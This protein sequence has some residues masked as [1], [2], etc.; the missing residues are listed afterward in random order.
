MRK[1]IL[2]VLTLLTAALCMGQSD[3]I[4]NQGGGATQELSYDSATGQMSITDAQGA[5]ITL[6]TGAS[7]SSDGQRGLV[8][9][10]L[11]GEEGL[12]LRGDGTWA[13]PTVGGDNWGS[14][15][16]QSS[17]FVGGNGTAANRLRLVQNGATDGQVIAWDNGLGEWD[18]R[19]QL[20]SQL[21]SLSA[22]TLELTNGG[23]V[24]LSGYLDN[25]DTQDLSLAANVLSL[26]DGGSVDLSGYLD[27]TDTQ[28]L[29]LAGTTL[30]L[31]NGGSVDLSALQDGT[32]TDDQELTLTGNTL[33]IEGGNSVSLAAYLDNTDTQDLSLAGSV[34]SLTNGGSVDLSSLGGG[35]PD[36]TL[37]FS[38]TT[39][40]I[41]GGNSVNLSSLLDNTDTQDL[42]LSGSVLSLTN[43]GSVDLSN[44]DDSDIQFI[45]INTSG[46]FLQFS[47]TDAN[48][49][50]LNLFTDVT[51]GGG[52]SQLNPLY[53][54]TTYI[55]TQYDLTNATA[56]A[57]NG[58]SIDS[59]SGDVVLGG[60]MTQKAVIEME[61]QAI[62]FNADNNG[63]TD[64]DAVSDS[65]FI[66]FIDGRGVV[67][68]FG[69]SD[70]NQPGYLLMDRVYGSDYTK[71]IAYNESD[72]INVG[73][74]S[75]ELELVG[76]EYYLNSGF[77]VDTLAA[78]TVDYLLGFNSSTGQFGPTTQ[79]TT[80]G[81]GSSGGG[82]FSTTNNVT[83]NAPG[84]YANDDFV[85]GSP[86]L[87]GNG[88]NNRR[89]FFDV[90]KGSLYANEATGTE[91][92]DTN[93]GFNV[94][95]A[96][97]NSITSGY[98]SAAMGGQNN[99]VVGAGSAAVACSGCDL[100]MNYSV[101]MGIGPKVLEPQ[102]FVH[103]NGSF[104]SGEVGQRQYTRLVL[105]GDGT[106]TSQFNVY[107]SNVNAVNVPT[108]HIWTG[109]WYC[110]LLVTTGGGI[111]DQGDYNP[112]FG[113]FYAYNRGGTMQVQYSVSGA[114]NVWDDPDM[115]NSD[116]ELN[117][118]NVNKAVQVRVQPST[119]G[120][121]NMET[122][123]VCVLEFVQTAY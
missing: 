111:V 92:D 86:Q 70:G 67:Y 46:S 47:L 55:A 76:F 53:V 26:T 1:L 62:E 11:S 42:S 30:S 31:T 69:V 43:G 116:V 85:F 18:A 109:T 20:D 120:D 24:D 80:N 13:N 8:P 56:S 48:T 73:D 94:F 64:F 2:T 74:L 40:S 7:S 78:G 44:V 61:N 68:G 39:L 103:G 117:A 3:K 25:T 123:C 95:N 90:S 23:S 118:D 59:G 34:L 83:S 102:S 16:A 113:D 32:G 77:S 82:A 72:K 6:M 54:D 17:G 98:A 65:I 14:Q 110:S 96:S 89:M 91:Y 122:R 121:S 15:V 97:R 22:N 87:D 36:Q 114:S 99:T 71:L 19:A 9:Q 100:P 52:G 105:Y 112:I 35:D 10:P 33:S 28:D 58:L 21:L 12:F 108:D 37:S 119:D 75:K 45:S 60:P 63:F 57:S 50:S 84:D 49:S 51:M 5:T 106:G 81:G 41:S 27:N 107:A 88:T 4:I 115:S 79:L 38:G 104:D 93:R 66:R 29:S 101:G